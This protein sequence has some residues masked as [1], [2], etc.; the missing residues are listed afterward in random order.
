MLKTWIGIPREVNLFGWLFL[1]G[2]AKRSLLQAGFQDRYLV[3]GG[4]DSILTAQ[5]DSKVKKVFERHSSTEF[6]FFQSFGKQSRYLAV[7]T[8]SPRISIFEW[9]K[10]PKYSKNNRNAEPKHVLRL[11]FIINAAFSTVQTFKLK[12]E[13]IQFGSISVSSDGS[14]L[15]LSAPR[16][17]FHVMAHPFIQTVNHSYLIKISMKSRRM[18]FHKLAQDNE[19]RVTMESFTQ[20]FVPSNCEKGLYVWASLLNANL[21][22]FYAYDESSLVFKKDESLSLKVGPFYKSLGGLGYDGASGDGSLFAYGTRAK[23]L[24]LEVEL[25]SEIIQ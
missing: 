4:C 10:N 23:L 15:L 14:Y 24:K 8:L 1:I 17:R 21:M 19:T 5:I 9:V 2:E 11:N 18:L 20:A 22:H 3:V 6:C 13:I 12:A 7:N 16:I 25:E